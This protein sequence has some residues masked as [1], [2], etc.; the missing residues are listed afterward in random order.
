VALG[1]NVLMVVAAIVSIVLTVPMGCKADD[2]A[3]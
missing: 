3:G 2:R 1:F